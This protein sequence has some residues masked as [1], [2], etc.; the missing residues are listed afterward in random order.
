M[1]KL[2]FT[3]AALSGLLVAAP[4]ADAANVTVVNFN[5]TK[6]QKL[7]A[8]ARPAPKAPPT[9]GQKTAAETK[10]VAKDV[11]VQAPA[12][13]AQ[14]AV[15]AGTGLYKWGNRLAKRMNPNDQKGTEILLMDELKKA[16][17]L[18]I[19]FLGTAK[20]AEP[21]VAALKSPTVPGSATVIIGDP[22]AKAHK[23]D[24]DGLL[25][26]T[27]FSV[28]GTP[29]VLG[30]VVAANATNLHTPSFAGNLA[31]F[32]TPEAFTAKLP[33][34]VVPAAGTNLPPAAATTNSA[35]VAPRREAA[36][37]AAPATPATPGK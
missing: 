3:F 12:N 6:T 7:D 18:G 11:G 26:D 27:N 24:L 17:G 20:Q 1:S 15:D 36:P 13:P 4:L 16:A 10:E 8:A 31:E 33:K 2:N 23:G 25:T 35:V 21:L 19:V 9:E 32:K 22:T 34:A 30:F 5:A 14:P 28:H 37:A 29:L